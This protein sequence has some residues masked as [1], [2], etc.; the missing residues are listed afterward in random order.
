NP[1]VRAAAPAA[2]ASLPAA[3]LRPP[4]FPKGSAVL[5]ACRVRRL[6]EHISQK[7][8]LTLKLKSAQFMVGTAQHQPP[9]F[10]PLLHPMEERAGERRRDFVGAWFP[11]PRS[12]PNSFFAGRGEKL[13]ALPFVTS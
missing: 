6:A 8:L 2:T 12:S 10:L 1:P 4:D 11:S 9:G 7:F 3:E 5:P 13:T